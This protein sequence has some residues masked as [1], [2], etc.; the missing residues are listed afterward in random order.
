MK[1]LFLVLFAMLATTNVFAG[2]GWQAEFT[3][4][5]NENLKGNVIA[6]VYSKWRYEENF[7]EPKPGKMERMNVTFYDEKGNSILHRELYFD[8]Y[9]TDVQSTLFDYSEDASG[10]TVHRP[11]I[12]VRGEKN[13]YMDFF[14]SLAS[15]DATYE[16]TMVSNTRCT[17]YLTID[18]KYDSN[19]VLTTYTMLDSNNKIV[20]KLVAKPSANG[21]YDYT[22]YKAS[23]EAV[24]KGVRTYKNGKLI[25]V[26]KPE[27]GFRHSNDIESF[28]MGNYSYDEKGRIIKYTQLSDNNQ[29][30]GLPPFDMQGLKY[31]YNQQGDVSQWI[32][33]RWGWGKDKGKMLWDSP[34]TVYTD[35]K[36]DNNNNWITR[37]DVIDNQK[38]IETREIIYCSSKEELQQK[39]AALRQSAGQLIKSKQK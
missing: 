16:N 9:Y 13:E 17:N 35:Y 29:D 8:S 22:I 1:K 7:G 38:Y 36:Y 32:K 18:Y 34:K 12:T 4:V 27:R 37:V 23:G 10:I 6:V 31:V 19:Q 21:N 30:G 26:D 25:K 14:P 28:K 5:K 11:Q 39:A 33:G 2:Y 24:E 15:L 3:N 20:A